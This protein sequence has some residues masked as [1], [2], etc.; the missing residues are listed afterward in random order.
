MAAAEGL[1]RLN[2]ELLAFQVL[3]AQLENNRDERKN[4]F[5]TLFLLSNMAIQLLA[6]LHGTFFLKR[7]TRDCLECKT[8]YRVDI[9]GL[10]FVAL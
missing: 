5:S 7:Y 4:Y 3:F 1:S 10:Y 9:E 8:A 6:V 2:E